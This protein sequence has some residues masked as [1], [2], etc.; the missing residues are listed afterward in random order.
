MK[1]KPEPLEVRFWR[2]VAKSEGCWLWT[3]ANT[4]SP[5]KYGRIG[6]GTGKG[7]LKAHRASW[8]IHFGAIPNGLWV[9]HKCDNPLCVRPDHLFLG[10][11]ADNMK[12]AFDKGRID[13]QKAA[14]A[15]RPG[16]RKKAA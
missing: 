6:D 9:L 11:R 4:G 7:A 3:G 15:P 16:R 10:T 12:D 8:L 14:S 13:I 1:G 5:M 2:F